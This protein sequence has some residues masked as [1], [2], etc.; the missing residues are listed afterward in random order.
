[1]ILRHG[2]DSCDGRDAAELSSDSE[3][4]VG[5]AG[6][7]QAPS[8]WAALIGALDSVAWRI[9]ERRVVIRV[10]GGSFYFRARG[11]MNV[12]FLGFRSNAETT[13]LLSECHATY[14]PQ[15]FEPALA[16]F[17]RL[18]LPTKLTT[19]VA[20]GR[21]VFIHAPRH[22]SLI[23][24]HHRFPMGP[25]CT[26]LA[27]DE[28]VAALKSLAEPAFHA[29]ATEAVQQ[30]AHT[31]LSREIFLRSF[32]DFVGIDRGLLTANAEA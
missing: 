2:L 11:P 8:A 4:R 15:P 5:F 13:R 7:L 1:M 19:Y 24:F 30:V 3:F 31:E 21:P 29:H 28:I 23:P 26:S 22:A 20:A 12:E 27:A 18:S 14:L 9:G 17:T 6:G 10:L 25:C 32:A 16:D